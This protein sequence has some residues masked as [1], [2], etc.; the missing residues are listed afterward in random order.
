VQWAPLD[1][2]GVPL[3]NYDGN[4]VRLHG[5]EWVSDPWG[6]SGFF[7][8]TMRFSPVVID[9]VQKRPVGV[10]PLFNEV[11]AHWNVAQT[12][13]A[14]L[15]GHWHTLLQIYYSFLYYNLSRSILFT[16]LLQPFEVLTYKILLI[17]FQMI[18]YLSYSCNLTLAL[19]IYSCNLTLALLT[20]H[21]YIVLLSFTLS[22]LG[23]SYYTTT[24]NHIIIFISSISASLI[25]GEECHVSCRPHSL[26]YLW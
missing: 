11:L 10:L 14:K 15:S 5:D 26:L 7:P 22:L 23:Q 25:M 2:N 3:E 13:V 20:Y 17:H 21:V 19:L 1:Q 18:L 9:W 12:Q 6:R 24:I 4:L 8:D 16:F